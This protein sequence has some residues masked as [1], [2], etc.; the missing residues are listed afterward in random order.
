M[1]N[2]VQY[3]TLGPFPGQAGFSIIE[4]LVAVALIAFAM[5]PL[6]A[7]Q[8]QMTR[9]TL[10]I[11]RAQETTTASET[12]LGIIRVLNPMIVPTG[13]Q[14]I[15]VGIMSWRATPV[16]PQK[17]ILSASG[18]A[19]RF[20]MRLYDV[21][22]EVSFPSGAKTNFTVRKMGWVATASTLPPS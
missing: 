5:T 10:A 9:T 21:Y 18:S 15:G 12:A 17:P 2:K 8:G 6:I 1:R 16:S 22:V 7:L 20:D 4:A 3:R 14:N 13:E 11:Q 19:G